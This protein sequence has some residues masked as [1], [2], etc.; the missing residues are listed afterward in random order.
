M[1][2]PSSAD[3]GPTASVDQTHAVISTRQPMRF[4]EFLA[5]IV[6]VMLADLL[7]FR[8]MGYSGP[9]L[10][11]L[12]SPCLFWLGK[13]EQPASF[14]TLAVVALM[15]LVSL[16]LVWSGSLGAVASAITLVI[17]LAMSAA[18]A[19]PLVLEGFVFASRVLADG[20]AWLIRHRL[21]A[22]RLGNRAP[23][24]AENRNEPP[25]SMLAAISSWLFPI[26]AAISF[27]GIFIFANPDL[28]DSVSIRLSRA[29]N[30]VLTWTRGISIWEFP[31]CIAAMLIGAG[32]LRPA[33]PF[34]RIGAVTRQQTP[35]TGN[36]DVADLY[37]AYRNTLLTLITLFT[38]YLMFEFITL[39]RRE[40]PDGFY[41]AGYAH[42]GAAWLTFALALATGTLSL[43]FSGSMLADRRLPW[44]RRLAGVWS[45][46]NLLLAAAVYNRLMIYVGY[47]GM[48]RMRTVGF[49]GI[50]LVV[51]GF[52]LVVYKIRHGR[53]FWWLIRAQL[54]A[55]LL[56]MMAHSVFPVDYVAHR[57]NVGRIRDDYLH[58]SVMIAVKQIDDEGM[59][60][61]M[62]LTNIDDSIIREGVLAILARRQQ[63][64]QA[65]GERE[66]W[67][68]TR[69]Q[70]AR[71]LFV[72]TVS[73][74]QDRIR[75]Y[76][77]SET[78]RNAAIARFREYAMQW[79]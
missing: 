25:P 1:Y 72:N 10:F 55:F 34:V 68:W 15:G 66:P 26:V 28:F 27:G 5:I 48:T 70:F 79:Y 65:W 17:A 14:S 75:P 21:P 74:H 73:Q 40:F 49:F 22:L 58:P 45:A 3:F 51:I 43:M 57:Y 35:V 60:P 36:Q 29:M 38:V 13:S 37:V 2:E 63:E 59:L 78:K 39:W 9:A 46:Q 64:V 23:V 32:L 42:Q 19:V 71:H 69:F 16:R 61:L 41:Y 20:T 31:F 33:R 56:T 44:L 52:L 77:E 4:R 7:I 24:A 6:W 8:S 18:G 11:L 47:N 62:S 54:L 67:D 12:L 53:G 30:Y 76:Q 50:T